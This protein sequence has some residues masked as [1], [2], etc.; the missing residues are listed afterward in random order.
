MSQ[1][2][3]PRQRQFTKTLARLISNVSSL[4]KRDYIYVAPS[5]VTTER[6]VTTIIDVATGVG[7]TIYLREVFSNS[8]DPEAIEGI[9]GKLMEGLAQNIAQTIGKHKRIDD[10][11]G[12]V[13]GDDR[14]RGVFKQLIS[15]GDKKLYVFVLKGV[16]SITV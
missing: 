8:L 14:F 11:M 5:P 2:I 12:L 15:I 3:S 6:A 1:E 13:I 16:N 4:R 7:N 10:P 9:C